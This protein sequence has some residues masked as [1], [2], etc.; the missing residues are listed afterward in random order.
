VMKTLPEEC[1]DLVYL[2]P[3]FN[4]N[5]TYNLLFSSPS[6]DQ[7]RAQIEAF[8]DTWHWGEQS[9]K[10]FKDIRKTAPTDVS[11]MLVA[12]IDFL[13]RNDVTA[14]LIMMTSRLLEIKRLM[15]DT[16]SIYLH[17]DPSASHYLKVIL[18]GV[19]GAENFRNEIIWKR[20][21]AKSLMTKRMPSNHDIIFYYTK[22]S[23][24]IF[25]QEALYTPYDEEDLPDTT[26]SKY[27]NRDPDGRR[28]T[29]DN[30]INPNSDRP[31][32]TYEFLG[33]T[34][35]WRWTKERMEK[36]YKNG[37][38][39]QSKP[40]AVPRMKRY[41]DEQKGIP[42][43]DV[44]IDINPLNSQAQ[45]RLG[46]PTQKPLSL[47]DRIILTSTKEGGT[48][49]DPFCGCG[50][51][52]HSAQK[53]RRDWIG[54]DITHLA[55]SLIER[56]LRDAFPDCKFETLGTP[57]DFE[58]AADLAERD[59]YQFQWWAISLIEAQPYKDKK[60]GA[61]GG[62]DGQ[63]F[64][65]DGTLR[66][67]LVS[68]KGGRNVSVSMIR[69]LIGTIKSNKADIG[70]FL[71]LANPTKPMLVEALNAGYYESK[72]YPNKDFPRIQI[73]TIEGLMNGTERAVYPDLAQ[74]GYNFKKAQKE[75][76]DGRQQKLPL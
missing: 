55:I 70:I 72:H 1:C 28:Y 48:I 62:I 69:D 41:L 63:I 10:E 19:F 44:W 4:S 43:D 22:T 17:C 51:A 30:L 12:L 56:R 33:V 65:D 13:E 52:V 58:S 60:K 2:D 40:G 49:L 67:I 34:K 35:V 46:Y 64:F 7:A 66:K 54:I 11:N 26:K 24:Y 50:T 8:D 53:N 29:L 6:G 15:K 73:I 31:N 5:A 23:N 27:S 32:L 37:I 71:T 47:L 18:D 61:D 75:K 16:A 25:N 36:A 74:G 20:T 45:E 9:E 21:T 3:P 57:K 76:E 68:V 14:Y 42:I 39:V 59:K 38:V